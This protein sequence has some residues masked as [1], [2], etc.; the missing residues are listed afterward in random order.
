MGRPLSRS[1]DFRSQ[2]R[3]FRS[4]RES[5]LKVSIQCVR[6]K[7]SMLMSHNQ[8]GSRCFCPGQSG[9]KVQRLTFYPE[10]RKYSPR[11]VS[12]PINERCTHLSRI[13]VSEPYGDQGTLTNA[14]PSDILTMID[15]LSSRMSSGIIDLL[16]GMEDFPKSS[17]S[18]VAFHSSQWM[19][20]MRGLERFLRRRELDS[21]P[22]R[23]TAT[24][25]VRIASRGWL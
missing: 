3:E 14:P 16:D 11:T 22:P 23:G 8:S 25:T 21:P 15:I 1:S 13:A 4:E 6:V 9:K 20:T 2:I 7:P 19:T 5:K 24:G 17:L 10:K 12:T 18:T